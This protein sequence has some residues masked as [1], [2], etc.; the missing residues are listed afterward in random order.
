MLRVRRRWL[1]LVPNLLSLSRLVLAVVFAASAD[2]WVRLACVVAAGA[3]DFLDG[4]LARRRRTA[5]RLGALLDPFAD[6][7]FVLTAISVFLF[8]GAVSTV[9]YFTF[10]LRDFATAI[11]FLIARAVPSL[12]S[13]PFQ[14]RL[15]GKGVTVLQLLTLLVLLVTPGLADPFI[16]AIGVL[17]A[18]AVADYT[19]ALWRL[20]TR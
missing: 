19:I 3:S 12:R 18:M 10:L 13:A 9:Q 5:S 4:W 8:E 7:V 11:G 2:L 16:V 1:L 15:L 20:R 6:R 14:A 17:S